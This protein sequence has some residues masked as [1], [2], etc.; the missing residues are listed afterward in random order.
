MTQVIALFA[1]FVLAAQIATF[2]WLV[3]YA[4][5]VDK[6]LRIAAVSMCTVEHFL[7]VHGDIDEETRDAMTQN[8]RAGL[9]VLMALGKEGL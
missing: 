5:R 7:A 9:R 4:R 2:W 3:R 1:T 8:A 6:C